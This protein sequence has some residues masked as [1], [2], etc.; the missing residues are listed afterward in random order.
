MNWVLV[1]KHFIHKVFPFV[2]YPSKLVRAELQFRDGI[3]MLMNKIASLL[4][5]AVV[6][7]TPIIL[8]VIKLAL[9][10][11]IVLTPL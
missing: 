1:A 10:P 3:M 7:A 2:I 6:V 5:M 11:A 8:Q 4:P 9:M